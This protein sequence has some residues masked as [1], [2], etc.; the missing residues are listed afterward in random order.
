MVLKNKKEEKKQKE[1]A[2][3]NG[4]DKEAFMDLILEKIEMKA[5]AM[6]N[7]EIFDYARGYRDHKIDGFA[8]FAPFDVTNSIPMYK[9][10]E[11]LNMVSITEPCDN[12]GYK[13]HFYVPEFSMDYETVSKARHEPHA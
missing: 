9:P 4:E 13:S 3:K 6:K 10:F 7:K 8:D 1:R 12:R 11:L 5:K 2:R